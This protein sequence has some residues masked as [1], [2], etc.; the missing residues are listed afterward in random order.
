MSPL[1]SRQRILDV[2]ARLFH[3]QGYHATGVATIQR[4]AGV[5]PGTLYHFFAS[6]EDLLQAVL[7]RYRERLRPEV[8]DPA[9]DRTDDPLERVF[10]LLA[11]YRHGLELT[12]CKQGCPIGNLA[13][14]LADDHPEV[15]GLIDA[16]FAGWLD[17]APPSLRGWEW[18][19]LDAATDSS[20]AVFRLDAGELHVLAWAPDGGLLAV[21]TGDGRILF[22]DP[23]TG[24][25]VRELEAH[26]REVVGLDFSPDGAVLASSGGDA[27]ARLWSVATGEE[28]LSF[29]AHTYPVSSVRFSPDGA[30]L[31]STSYERPTGGEVRVWSAS[32]GAER[33]RFQAGYAPM[34]CADWSPDGR[35]VHAGSWVGLFATW[36][37]GGDAEGRVIEVGSQDDYRAVNALA[38]SPDG[39]LVVLGGKD[40]QLHLFD[41]ATGEKRLQ[42]DAHER[43]VWGVALAPDGERRVRVEARRR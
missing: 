10:A 40:D 34:T 31:A 13:L 26:G 22:V 8:T 12:D 20:T 42:I 4:E 41:A 27:R 37:L 15:R 6:K 5:N 16:N 39:S 29:E 43:A 30:L 3:E 17:G 25:A 14:E 9:E 28:L 38:V 7:E 35:R 19:H 24:E 36:E 21:G 33:H 32:D 1:D 23:G 18:R 11:L 2:A